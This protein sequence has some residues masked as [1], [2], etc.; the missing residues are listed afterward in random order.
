MSSITLKGGSMN[1]REA[2]MGDA[3]P[4]MTLDPITRTTLALYCG[5][6][7]DHHPMHVDIDFAKSVGLGDV[8]GHGMLSMAYVARYVNHLAPPRDLRALSCRFVDVTRVGDV[9][10]L[11]SEVLDVT[12]GSLKD[13]LRLSVTMGN[14]HGVVQI[15][16]HATIALPSQDS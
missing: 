7:N 9:P 4:A 1:L 12:T 13:L 8:I 5:A 16:A 3:L 10:T 11:T 15:R 14:Q 6:S 2:R